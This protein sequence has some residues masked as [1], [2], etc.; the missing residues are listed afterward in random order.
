VSLHPGAWIGLP[1]GVP[2]PIYHAGW[3]R[4][5]LAV[6]ALAAAAA[7]A[8]G[9][10]SLAL[11]LAIV[12]AVLAVGFWVAAL[13]RPYGVLV[14]AGATRWA[15][16]ISVAG[17]SGGEDGIVGGGPATTAYWPALARRVPPDVVMLIP[18]VL[19]VLVVPVGALAIAL[20]G[21][22]REATLAAILWV[23]AGTGTSETLRGLGFVPALWSRPA[24]GLL[25]I[26]TVALVLLAG[27]SRWPRA[28]LAAAILLAAGWMLL[29]WRDPRPPLADALLALTLDQHVWLLAGLAGLRR[30][31]PGRAL[32]GGGAA[33]V[34][35]RALGGPGDAWAG[36]AFYRLGL[37]MG[38]ATWIDGLDA[39]DLVPPRLAPW[40]ERWRLRPERLPT[41]LAVALCLA[42][43]FL[44]WWDPVRT[45]ALARAS[46]EPF[47]DALQDAMQ[48]MRANA[49][50]E[51]AVLAHPGYAAAVSV[52]GGRRV[53]RAP[54]LV[55]TGDDERR[56]RLERA[57]VAGHPPPALLQRYSLRYVF[58][59]PGQF[60]EYGIEEPEDLERRGGVRLLYANAKGMHVYELLAAGRPEPFK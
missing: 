48:W 11:A 59:A 51:S 12:F 30:H 43:G 23:G 9:R 32:V 49:D 58:L 14:D 7:E 22:R 27:R 57:V 21:G 29:G 24:A 36:L 10:R 52:L 3:W 1:P 20:A 17:H 5:L 28:T 26:A 42:G 46:L 53:L 15:G 39:A 2:A 18:T 50:R 37:I 35:V 16:E 38:A 41:A 56:L 47:P 45:D 33:L 54:G 6:V 34:L 13:E 40:C 8:R 19:P 25:W 44:A 60:R 4:D 55:E 31:S